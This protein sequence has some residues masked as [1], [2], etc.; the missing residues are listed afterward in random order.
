MK[1][2]AGVS[3]IWGKSGRR[4]YVGE[5]GFVDMPEPDALPLKTQAGGSWSMFEQVSAIYF[6]GVA[7]HEY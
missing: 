3:E 1:A 2:P 4:Y 6:Q 7:Q 5:S